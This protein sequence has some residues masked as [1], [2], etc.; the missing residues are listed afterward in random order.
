MFLNPKVE[1]IFNT[2]GGYNSNEI[3]E[4]IDYDL[5]KKHPKPFI[6]YSDITALNLA[7]YKKSNLATINSYF[8][9]DLH[10]VK[11]WENQIEQ[12]IVKDTFELKNQDSYKVS[13]SKEVL[14]TPKIKFLEG[15]KETASGKVL[16]ANLSTFNLLLGTDYMPNLDGHILFLEY[17]KEE[18]M[19]MPSLERMLWQIRQNGIFD[20]IDG[21]VFGLLEPRA[22]QQ[23]K[24]PQT[25]KQILQDVTEDYNFLVAFDAQFGHVY[26]SFVLKNGDKTTIDFS[27][28]NLD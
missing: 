15:K 27:S 21:L 25:I 13:Y 5:I 20:K 8:V 23:E 24:L 11:N 28:F 9:K 4:F 14:K 1:V 19:A 26:P 10:L 18:E 12:A 7:L 2:L 16:A 6:G 17:D 22:K 3:L